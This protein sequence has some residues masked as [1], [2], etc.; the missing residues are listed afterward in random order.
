MKDEL[1]ESKQ[2]IFTQGHQVG[3]LAQ[4]LFPDG[5]KLKKE[6]DFDFDK[7]LELT[8]QYLSKPD[9]ALYEAPFLHNEI[10]S[11]LDILVSKN[12]RWYAYEVKS[13]T[14]I[15]DEVIWDAA[16]QYYVIKNSGLN[17]DDFFIV[18]INNQYV[19][20][21]EIDVKQLFT[22]ESVRDRI[23][24]LQEFVSEKV[25]ELKAVLKSPSVPDIDI[26]LYCEKPYICD[27]MGHCWKHIPDYSVFNIGN[28]GKEKQYDLY[29]NGIVRIEDIPD[30]YKLNDKQRTEVSSALTNTPVI[31]KQEIRDF[32]SGINYPVYFLDF[33]TFFPAVPMFDNSRPYRQISFQYSLHYLDSKDSDLQHF[34]YLAEADYKIDPRIGFIEALL[35][36]TEK[37]GDILVYNISFE[38]TRLIELAQD[39]P[40][41]SGAIA[42]IISRIKDLMIPFQN[43]YYYTPAMR[44]SH[45]IKAVL[46]ALM[47]GMSYGD[48][49]IN[50]G[51]QA[52]SAFVNLYEETN[53]EI[54][55]KTRANLL[56][57]CKLDTL[58]MVKILKVLE[59]V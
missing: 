46:P 20:H 21:G 1:S 43:R 57:Y 40:Q 37:P 22:I 56:D 8:K 41:Y 42:D 27:F 14:G 2:T 13:S 54:I 7:G 29:Y 15:K 33:E 39:F 4:S 34:E 26:G 59:G 49:E 11:I 47:P 5:I 9:V 36:Q 23:L 10:L 38:R 25:E 31:K 58:A 32:L 55:A 24:P 45:S 48:L 51:G 28:L 18:Y 12:G 3:E 16:L 30:D 35:A 52:S 53:T 19:R 6:Y 44:G 50:Q 17:I